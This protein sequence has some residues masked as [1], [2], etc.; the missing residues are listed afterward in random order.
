MHFC[1]AI[2]VMFVILLYHPVMA[3]DINIGMG[4]DSFTLPDSLAG[5][6][7]VSFYKNAYDSLGIDEEKALSLPTR[8]DCPVNQFNPNKRIDFLYEPEYIGSALWGRCKDVQ[9]QD[10]IAYCTFGAGI[11]ILNVTD[12]S[13]PI[14]LSKLFTQSSPEQ[15]TIY[16]DYAYVACGVYGSAMLIV[17]ISDPYKPEIVGR[18]G[19]DFAAWK[20]VL[21]TANVPMMAIVCAGDHGFHFVDVSDPTNPHGISYYYLWNAKDAIIVGDTAFVVGWSSNYFV[22]LDVTD[23]ENY[24]GFNYISLAT[25]SMKM[26]KKGDY[27]YVVEEDFFEEPSQIQIID[28]SDVY[29][30]TVVGTYIFDPLY[31][32]N[33]IELFGDTIAVGMIHHSECQFFDISTLDTIKYI[34][35]VGIENEPRNIDIIGN[36]MYTAGDETGFQDRKSVV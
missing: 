11:V 16:Q 2:I 32:P 36:F 20:I 26:A 9:V 31:H 4:H 23:Y 27:I 15:I 22:A 34:G 24:Y 29:N 19:E 13:D 28:V 7:S 18:Y 33:D 6:P 35:F 12:P 21:D 30:L 5:M 17:D 14:L 3:G 25:H 10:N 8:P 1:K